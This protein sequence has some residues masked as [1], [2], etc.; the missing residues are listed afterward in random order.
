MLKKLDRQLGRYLRIYGSYLLL[1]NQ[2]MLKNVEEND[3]VF[4]KMSIKENDS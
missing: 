3:N 2:D 1:K 4:V